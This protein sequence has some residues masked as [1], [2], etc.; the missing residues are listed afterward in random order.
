KAQALEIWLASSENCNS[1][2]LY[3]RVAQQRGYGSALRYADGTPG[4]SRIP[5]LAIFKSA[6]AQDML[7]QLPPDVG[8]SNPNWDVQLTV[9]VVDAG[10]V[11]TSGNIADSADNTELKQPRAVMLPPA[12]PADGD[13]AL[14]QQGVYNEFFL[15]NWN[16]EYFVDVALGKRPKRAP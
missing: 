7:A 15:K 9:L 3:E 16:L 2:A 6:L 14:S 13:P 12:A 5:I 1:C 10:R 8:P 4:N 11:V